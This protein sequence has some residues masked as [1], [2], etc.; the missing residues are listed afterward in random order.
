MLHAAH[1]NKIPQA[2]S[3]MYEHAPAT[4]IP[5]VVHSA[6]GLFYFAYRDRFQC[7]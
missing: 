3:S 6:A 7:E 1:W 4:F 5:K 2:D